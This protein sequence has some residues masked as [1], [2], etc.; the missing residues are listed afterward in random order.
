MINVIQLFLG[1]FFADSII[2]FDFY[3]IDFPDCLENRIGLP[4]ICN[5]LN[6]RTVGALRQ[7][8]DTL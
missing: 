4:A 8:P 5:M 1:V 6:W 7:P 2:S 3:R